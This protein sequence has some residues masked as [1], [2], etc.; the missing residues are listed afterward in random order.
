MVVLSPVAL[1]YPAR[2]FDYGKASLISNL[3]IIG[4]VDLLSTDFKNIGLFR[5]SS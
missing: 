3:Y 2:G 5:T 4:F 1:S